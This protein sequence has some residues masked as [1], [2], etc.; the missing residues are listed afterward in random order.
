MS[1]NWPPFA[2]KIE[3]VEHLA[4]DLRAGAEELAESFSGL[5][6]SWTYRV[7]PST[8][9]AMVARWDFV[10]PDLAFYLRRMSSKVWGLGVYCPC[11]PYEE[12]VNTFRPAGPCNHGEVQVLMKPRVTGAVRLSGQDQRLLLDGKKTSSP[13]QLALRQWRLRASEALDT[14]GLDPLTAHVE[15]DYL[16]DMVQSVMARFGVP[17]YMR[18]GRGRCTP[19]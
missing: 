8:E 5:R 12:A 14:A 11:W 18:E 6:P 9:T 10:T 7:Y 1:T 17:D 2:A 16:I 13:T 3:G 15:A 19:D 4:E